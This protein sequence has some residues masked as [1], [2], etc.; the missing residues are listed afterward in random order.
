MFILPKKEINYEEYVETLNE[1]PIFVSIVKNFD[2]ERIGLQIL[3][4]EEVVKEFTSYNQDG[5][6]MK[7]EEGLND[8]DFTARVE[9][10][11]IKQLTSPKEQ[12]WI[13]KHPMEAAIKY[14]GKIKL[15][16]M[17]KLKLLKLLN[18]I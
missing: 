13:E 11:T 12:A 10:E 14:A 15:P 17:V 4:N 1:S 16:F 8:P 18:K 6:I 7:F 2:Y 9:E 5:K 3:N